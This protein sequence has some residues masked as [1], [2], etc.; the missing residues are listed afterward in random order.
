MDAP[1]QQPSTGSRA[2]RIYL[3]EAE[4]GDRVGSESA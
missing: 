2:E 4:G 3:K 1:P